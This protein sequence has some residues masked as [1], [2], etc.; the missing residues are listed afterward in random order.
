MNNAIWIILIAIVAFAVIA[1]DKFDR[2]KD[3]T[4]QKGKEILNTKNATEQII[5]DY[6]EKYNYTIQDWGID[7]GK[8]R[9]HMD[10]VEDEDCQAFFNINQMRCSQNK[11]CYIEV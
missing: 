10:C 1:P 5:S 7:F 3:V 9:G 11:T 8:I 4:I 2:A 6:G